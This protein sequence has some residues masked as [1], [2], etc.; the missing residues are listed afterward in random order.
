[1]G[2]A[3]TWKGVVKRFEALPKEAR[4]YFKHFPKLAEEFPWDVSLAYTFSRVELAHNMA[5]YCGAVKLHRA[6]GQLARTAVQ[7]HHMTR[8]GF[9][10][11]FTTIHG[12]PIPD[13]IK[14][15]LEDAEGIRDKNDRRLS[16]ET[17]W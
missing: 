14:Q 16:C 6:D 9:L 8:T 2:I 13:P 11:L 7:L 1:M 10:E 4:D 3:K 17:P 12:H 5:I 15:L